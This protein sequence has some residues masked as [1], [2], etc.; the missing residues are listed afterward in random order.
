MGGLKGR[1]DCKGR[2]GNWEDEESDIGFFE[3]NFESAKARARARGA[4]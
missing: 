4:G 1:E 2:M 3:W